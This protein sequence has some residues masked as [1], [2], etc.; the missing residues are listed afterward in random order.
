MSGVLDM[1]VFFNRESGKVLREVLESKQTEISRLVNHL[2]LEKIDLQ[3]NEYVV[4]ELIIKLKVMM[5]S[6]KHNSENLLIDVVSNILDRNLKS[7]ISC[8]D[9]ARLVKRIHRSEY[10]SG[11]VRQ[12]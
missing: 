6:G 8:G 3:N 11:V 10:L 9:F 12:L 5:L 1:G 4:C 7:K 2:G